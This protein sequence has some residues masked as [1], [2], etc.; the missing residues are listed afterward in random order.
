MLL[1]ERMRTLA[2]RF[3]RCT[4]RRA[5]SAI[6]HEFAPTVNWQQCVDV[7]VTAAI[8]VVGAEKVD[9]NVAQMMISEDFGAFLQK[10]PAVSSF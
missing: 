5:S 6:P 8:N 2:K 4:V 3:A 7:A 9:G 10:S 1:E